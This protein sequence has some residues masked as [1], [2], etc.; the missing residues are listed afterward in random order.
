MITEYPSLNDCHDDGEKPALASILSN[1]QNCTIDINI[2]QRT[3]IDL[4]FFT[5]LIYS[6]IL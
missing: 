4:I 1:V 2:Q 3:V 5:S 6:F